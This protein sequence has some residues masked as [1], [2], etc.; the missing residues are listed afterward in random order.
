MQENRVGRHECTRAMDHHD[1]A[2]PRDAAVSEGHLLGGEFLVKTSFLLIG[3]TAGVK[4]LGFVRDQAIAFIFGAGPVTD[5]Y[6]I[7][8]SF[9]IALLSL[10][11]GTFSSALVPVLTGLWR[12][13][14]VAGWRVTREIG[15]VYVAAVLGIAGVVVLAAP[16]LLTHV[17]GPGLPPSA[18]PLAV[19]MVRAFGIGFLFWAMMSFAAGILN[20]RKSFVIPACGPLVLNAVILVV[21]LLAGRRFGSA[22]LIVG[23]VLGMVAQFLLL[24]PFVVGAW[25]GERREPQAAADDADVQRRV[26][27][28]VGSFFF[29]GLLYQAPGVID[30]AFASGL[31]TGSV[32]ILTFAQKLMQLPLGLFVG[33]VATVFYTSLSEAW[34]QRNHG[35]AADELGLALGITLLVALPAAAGLAALNGPIVQLVFQ[36]G[37]F[38]AAAARLTASVLRYYCIGLPLVGANLVLIRNAYAAEDTVS[39][40]KA[41]AAALVINAIGDWTLSRLM[42]PSGIAFA[43]SLG[44][45]TLSCFL[46]CSWESRFRAAVMRSLLTSLG[47]ALIGTAL[48]VGTVLFL[49][50]HLGHRPLWVR[51]GVPGVLGLIVYVLSLLV[52]QPREVRFLMA[53]LRA[54]SGA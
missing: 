11:G 18:R 27:A 29:L 7:A 34:A 2:A 37:R 21:L 8:L 15:L 53:R 28:L 19:L 54:S 20:S 47:R 10:V 16:W 44:A 31:A 46:L 22:A 14:W 35:K 23:T 13:K 42:G 45:V 24:A 49:S 6:Y 48:M 38:D 43:S 12:G 32:A 39:P 9:V 40:L 4:L 5:G 33:G 3:L 41:Y 1:V 50:S 51:L 26:W 17:L 36:H 30:K 52:S 25:A